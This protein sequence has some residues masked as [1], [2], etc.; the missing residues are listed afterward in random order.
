[1]SRSGCESH[2]SRRNGQTSGRRQMM[3]KQ[4]PPLAGAG[5]QTREPAIVLEGRGLWLAR[6]L[7]LAVL[8][9][10]V[11]LFAA[12]LP[13]RWALA[14]MEAAAAPGRLAQF[15]LTVTVYAACKVGADLA[16]ALVSTAVGV[17]IFVR[18]ARE[19]MALFVA[20]MLV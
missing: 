3:R 10:A 18:R 13:G 20:T 7:W 12:S 9:V 11:G 15:G 14:A 17:L 6:A 16:L 2:E 1:M 8:L 4:K 5:G 19:L